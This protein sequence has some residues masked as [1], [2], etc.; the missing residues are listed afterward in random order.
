MSTP[1]VTVDL[2]KSGSSRKGNQQP[3]LII[4]AVQRNLL[5]HELVF[6]LPNV[7]IMD[8]TIDGTK[9]SASW[10]VIEAFALR[11]FVGDDVIKI[12]RECRLVGIGID[13]QAAPG[14]KQAFKVGTVGKSPRGSRFVDRMVRAICQ[15]GAA[16]NAVLSDH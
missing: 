14:T 13:R 12:V 3:A 9:G 8:T 2:L 10:L 15:A 4:Q 5:G 11:A 1:A 7:R 16:I 6:A